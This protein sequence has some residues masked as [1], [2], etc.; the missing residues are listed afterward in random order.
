MADLYQRHNP[1]PGEGRRTIT[2]AE[3]R[4]ACGLIFSGEDCWKQWERHLLEVRVTYLEN[5]LEH[6]VKGK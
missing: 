3:T 1:T 4:C 5:V 6:G 2:V